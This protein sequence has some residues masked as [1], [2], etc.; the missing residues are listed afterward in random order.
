MRC[1]R[2]CAI[3]AVAVVTIAAFAAEQ[4]VMPTLGRVHTKAGKSY[5][6]EVLKD[7]D[8]AITLRLLDTGKEAEYKKAGLA[9]V[10]PAISEGDAARYMGLPQV[11]AWKV[12]A[13][14]RQVPAVGKVAK[15]NPNFVYLTLGADS[16]LAVGQELNVFRNSGDVIDPDTKA[17]LASDRQKIAKAQVT[18][19]GKNYS[20]AKIL[21]DFEAEL[22]VGDEVELPSEKIRVAVFPIDEQNGNGEGTAIAEQMTTSLVGKGI[23]VVER[24]LLKS[25]LAELAIQNTALFDE[26]TAQTV[27]KQLGANVVLAGKIVASGKKSEVHV[28]LIQVSSGTILLAM[29]QPLS[30]TGTAASTGGG[31]GSGGNGGAGAGGDSA[32][33]RDWKTFG[34]KTRWPSYLHGGDAAAIGKDGLDVRKNKAVFTKQ[35]DFLKRN[36]VFEAE[37]T[38]SGAGGR[39]QGTMFC[40][41]GAA[42]ANGDAPEQYVELAEFPPGSTAKGHVAIFRKNG[43]PGGAQEVQ[44]LG[45]IAT[46]GPH[47]LR[48]E[49]SGTAVTFSVDVDNDGKSA[50][51]VEFTVPDFQEFA[52]FLHEKNSYLFIGGG[53][54][55]Q[56]VRLTTGP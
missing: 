28:R 18:E 25:A 33:D 8:T 43:G 26:K 56:K 29:S 2:Y 50:D 54:V 15:V 6:G 46:N 22:K 49:K 37:Y 47:R 13:L 10:E 52:P 1:V 41:I 5:V 40:G 20:K 17:V 23:D 35:G 4:P 24:S 53:V 21:G 32:A 12:A 16:G 30:A 7:S 38:F 36:F 45:A 48:I 34:S 55:F 19:V 31:S 11:L 27:G 44:K 39:E 14:A 51:D 42:S 3:F 9:K